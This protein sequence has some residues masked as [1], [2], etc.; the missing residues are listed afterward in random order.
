MKSL[1]SD[2]TGMAQAWL[3]HNQIILSAA[4]VSVACEE[5]DLTF[6]RLSKSCISEA[7]YQARHAAQGHAAAHAT[8]L[9]K[10]N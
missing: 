5:F 1:S 3:I 7:L 8:M 4:T 10:N 6:E 2:L 9:D